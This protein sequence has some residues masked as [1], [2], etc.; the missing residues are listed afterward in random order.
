MLAKGHLVYEVRDIRFQPRLSTH[1]LTLHP[2]PHAPCQVALS[3][4][5][6]VSSP[7]SPTTSTP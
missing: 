7:P 4:I 6:G 3:P 2:T 1:T 5:G